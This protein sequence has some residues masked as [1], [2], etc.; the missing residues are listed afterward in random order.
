MQQEQPDIVEKK[1]LKG[2]KVRIKKNKTG[3]KQHVQVCRKR[4]GRQ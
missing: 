4:K 3:Q 1:M 2:G